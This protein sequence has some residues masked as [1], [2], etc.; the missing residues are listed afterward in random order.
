MILIVIGLFLVASN[1]NKTPGLL[2]IIIG[3]L[4]FMPGLL[5]FAE[6]GLIRLWPLALVALGGYILLRQKEIPGKEEY[7]GYDLKDTDADII[8]DLNIF[9]GSNRNIITQNFKGGRVT[10]VFG[11]ADYNFTRAGLAQ[12]VA[13]LDVLTI[14][15]GTKVV[16]P[17]DWAVTI[18]VVSIFGG[19]ADKR[20]L[21]NPANLIPQ[22]KLVIKGFTIFGGGEVKNI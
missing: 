21:A 4:F 11:G 22:N 6:M 13:V 3:V 8:D 17:S 9:G 10:C 12:N 7:K 19:F 15:G 1:K 2:M 16:V 20:H 5:G 18:D 14:F